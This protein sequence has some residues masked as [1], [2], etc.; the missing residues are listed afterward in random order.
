MGA[1]GR[2]CRPGWFREQFVRANMLGLGRLTRTF[3]R[4]ARGVVYMKQETRPTTTRVTR[5]RSR[6]KATRHI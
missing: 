1:L 2:S 4:R 5:E 6:G 3:S